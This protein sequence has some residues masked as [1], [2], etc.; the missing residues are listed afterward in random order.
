M[1]FN[2]QGTVRSASSRALSE[3]S[4]SSTDLFVCQEL[5]SILSKL[6]LA[7]LANSRSLELLYLSTSSFIC[8]EL[9]SFLSELFCAAVLPDT[10]FIRQPAYSITLFTIC[11]ALFMT[12]FI[13]FFLW[14]FM[15]SH[16]YFITILLVYNFHKFT[17]IG[18]KHYS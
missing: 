16:A 14:S 5:F 8:Q 3:L 7:A 15:P 12:F 6:F 17:F 13:I 1:L 9:F 4:Y 11:Q 18:L 2:L 10:P